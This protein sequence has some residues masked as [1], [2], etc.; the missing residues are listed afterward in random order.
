M[1]Q[2]LP[3]G[4]FAK[5]LQEKRAA[6]RRRKLLIWGISAGVIVVTLVVFYLA[7]LSPVFAARQVVVTG[8]ELL[9]ADEVRQAAAVQ[10]GEPLARQDMAGIAA[11]V[12]ALP[13]VK[14][15][16]VGVVLPDTVEIAVTERTVV[17]QRTNEGQVEW[18]DADGVVFHRT[19]KPTKG[20]VQVLAPTAD[21]RLLRDIATVAAHL[22][23]TVRKDLKTLR[24]DGIDDIRLV[25]TEKRSVLWGNAAESE[26]KGEVLAV[27]L[28]KE[29][30]VYDVSAPRTPTTR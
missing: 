10:V 22:P 7:F 24:A 15:A 19:A 30:R 23:E 21:E 11:R 29:A 9:D 14:E 2:P 18:I 26:L 8:T 27:L 16:T 13:A 6:A 17:F 4:A 25:L 5:A 28:S 3:P 12:Q 1:T 20:V